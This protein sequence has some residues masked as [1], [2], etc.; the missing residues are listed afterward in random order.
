MRSPSSRFVSTSARAASATDEA[1]AM[2][3]L[4]ASPPAASGTESSET[5]LFLVEGMR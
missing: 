5:L 4:A 2:G 1:P 3:D